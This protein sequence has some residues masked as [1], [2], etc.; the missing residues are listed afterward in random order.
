[1][2]PGFILDKR[3]KVFFR[4]KYGLFW[5]LVVSKRTFIKKAMELAY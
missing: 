3:A 2:I 4:E 5:R 1:M